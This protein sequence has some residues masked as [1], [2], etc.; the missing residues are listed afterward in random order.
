MCLRGV[1]CDNVNYIFVVRITWAE[2]ND[3]QLKK[4]C[5]EV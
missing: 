2:G 4:Y 1:V 5:N 3:V